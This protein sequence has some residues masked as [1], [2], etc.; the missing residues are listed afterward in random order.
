VSDR[1]VPPLTTFIERR[2]LAGFAAVIEAARRELSL[3]SARSF[4]DV[5]G[6]SGSVTAEVSRG[7]PRVVVLEPRGTARTKGKKRRPAIEFV[8]G[9]AE[10]IPFPDG[11]FDRV[12]ATGSLHHFADVTR[13]LSEMHRVLAP[14]GRIAIFEFSPEGGQGKF[15]VKCACHKTL[16][17]PADLAE[18]V[19]QA[20]FAEVRT[21]G[22][23]PG[24]LV[25]GLRP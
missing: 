21:Q 10:E 15:L 17:R 13:G 2:R 7:V 5:G 4:L 9:T 25:F 6:G 20:G 14:R 1:G 12:M 22:V 8:E 18:L 23:G 11:S 19:R 24:Y 16:Q 3:D